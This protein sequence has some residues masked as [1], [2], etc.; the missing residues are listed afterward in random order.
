VT[1]EQAQRCNTPEGQA[2]FQALRVAVLD[3]SRS[4][5][6]WG[7]DA[8]AIQP[9]TFGPSHLPHLFRRDYVTNSNDSYWLSNPKQPLEGFSRIIG[10]EGTERSLRT[11]LGL[12]M[13]AGKRFTL[14]Q[15]MRDAQNDRVYSGELFRDDLVRMC[16]QGPPDV[17]AACPV[18]KAWDLK[19]DLDS[20]GA[21]LFRR[22]ATRALAGPGGV[23][24]PP[25]VFRVP[26]DRNDPV[27]TP[28]GLNTES[29]AVRQALSDAV[30]DLRSNGIPLDARLR[31][32][33]SEQ[34][35]SQ[36]IPVP[37]GPHATGVFNVIT[38]PFA[39]AKG[40]PDV[41]HG[42]SFV[43]AAE[44]RPRRCPESRSILTYSQSA[45][46]Q[47]SGHMADQTRLFSRKRWVDMRF[48]PE[49][50][51][52]DR[53]LRVLQLG[54]VNVAGFKSVGVAGRSG[55]LRV[56]LRRALRVRS[57]VEVRRGG[58]RLARFHRGRSF[59]WK[60]HL[61]QGKYRAVFSI[62]SATGRLDRR[63]VRF[64]VSGGMVRARQARRARGCRR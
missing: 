1:D 30:Q 49:E 55:R 36:V 21:V 60:R 26:F 22:F 18:L 59:T 5:C 19:D 14:K 41:N 43:M 6:V 28:R 31:E 42:S 46:D 40:F 52:R 61:A 47:R 2:T 44:L 62:R 12:L 17:Q 24:P 39:G 15:L 7:R 45:T 25:A 54:C 37:G 29:P 63:S 58:R 10:D 51:L 20:R 4:D 64:S 8:D 27:N 9:G 11:R 57:T 56:R 32:Y 50:I 53:K 48:C 3:G 16:E 38:A 33:Q 35:G 23:L 13:V 34:R